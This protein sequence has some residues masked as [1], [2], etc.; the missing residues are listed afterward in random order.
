VDLCTSDDLLKMTCRNICRDLYTVNTNC[1]TFVKWL[2]SVS[3]QSNI[4][5]LAAASDG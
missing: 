5:G 2:V 3:L 4:L 1:Y